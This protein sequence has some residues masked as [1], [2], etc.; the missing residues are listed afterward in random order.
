MDLKSKEYP[1]FFE[2][3]LK[4]TLGDNY[5]ATGNFPAK[6]ISGLRKNVEDIPNNKEEYDKLAEKYYSRFP[7][8]KSSSVKSSSA[9]S[10]P[11][12]SPAELFGEGRIPSKGRERVSSKDILK[13]L[14]SKKT[15]SSNKTKQL[16]IDIMQILRS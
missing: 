4:K 11:V 2:E 10:N 1:L 13:H 5:G 9:E 8:K 12:L 6:V 7:Q 14:S 15:I 16:K 3:E